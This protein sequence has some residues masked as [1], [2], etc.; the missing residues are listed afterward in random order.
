MIYVIAVLIVLLVAGAAFT[1][2]QS[3]D[4]PERV[5]STLEVPIA[6]SD[7]TIPILFGKRHLRQFLL[8]WYGDVAIKKV[9]VDSGAKK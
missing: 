2:L 5:D 7:K 6:E 1:L 9:K 8:G 3:T 4:V